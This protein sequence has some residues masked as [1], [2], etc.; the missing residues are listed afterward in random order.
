MKTH[1]GDGLRDVAVA[2]IDVT[3]RL[4][5]F[6]LSVISGRAVT[7]AWKAGRREDLQERAIVSRPSFVPFER[8][9]S[10]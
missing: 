5:T 6:G 3:S 1:D 4:L 8:F 10:A 2:A 7:S 9:G